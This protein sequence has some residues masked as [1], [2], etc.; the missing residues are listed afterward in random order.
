M[1]ILYIVRA[2]VY[3]SLMVVYHCRVH[4]GLIP[5]CLG[6]AYCSQKQASRSSRGQFY[7]SVIYYN[8]LLAV[9]IKSFQYILK[10][11][12]GCMIYISHPNISG[13][14]NLSYILY[15]LKQG[16]ITRSA[17]IQTLCR[18]PNA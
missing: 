3:L 5:D 4:R 17:Y 7:S 14:I 10:F 13:R 15:N 11:V 9:R 16:Q 2:L 6:F 1:N 8:V 12:L 18:K